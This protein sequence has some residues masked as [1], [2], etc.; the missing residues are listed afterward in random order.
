MDLS[1]KSVNVISLFA[2]D[3]AG[4]SSFYQEVLGMPVIFEDEHMVLFKFEN[5][6]ISVRD[7]TE[8][9]EL[10]APASLA[11]PETGSRSTLAVFVDDVDAM[12]AELAELGV[13]LLNGPEDRPWGMRTACFADPAGHIWQLSQ[14]LDPAP[15]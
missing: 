11:S 15:G 13:V 14:D 4:T 8:A 6:M 5:V 3:L 10:I 1:H 7:A 9:A 12:C 2:E